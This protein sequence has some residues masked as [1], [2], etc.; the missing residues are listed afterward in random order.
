M[1]T[2]VDLALLGVRIICAVI[3]WLFSR[4]RWLFPVRLL[5]IAALLVLASNLLTRT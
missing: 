4:P 5:A 3:R 1:I 2:A